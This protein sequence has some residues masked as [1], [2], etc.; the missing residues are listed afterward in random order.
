MKKAIAG[1]LAAAAVAVGVAAP[2]Q[3]I[4]N[5]TSAFDGVCAQLQDHNSADGVLIVILNLRSQG[6]SDKQIVT[7]VV[8][9]VKTVCPQYKAA[10]LAF[11][12]KYG[13]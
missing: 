13:G 6:Y 5:G 10:V 3:A 11:A 9:A 1:V 4:D 2:A 12:D 7:L 8:G